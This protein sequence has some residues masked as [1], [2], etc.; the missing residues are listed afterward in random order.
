MTACLYLTYTYAL[1]FLHALVSLNVCM[2]ACLQTLVA[3]IVHI[4][5]QNQDIPIRNEIQESFGIHVNALKV[6]ISV[7]ISMRYRET[8]GTSSDDLLRSWFFA[9]RASFNPHL[10]NHPHIPL[11]LLLASSRK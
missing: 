8:C 9:G 7:D 3:K 4:S 2:T 10:P 6:Y 1:V 5:H 11:V